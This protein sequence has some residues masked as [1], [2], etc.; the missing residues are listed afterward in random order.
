MINDP[1]TQEHFRKVCKAGQGA[2]CCR[3]LT[4][5][6]KGIC[7]EK[8]SALRPVF[9]AK[10]ERGDFVARGDNCEGRLGAVLPS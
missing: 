1:F 2:A 9:D 7:C 8:L 6:A 10:A 4:A 5:S 3:Y